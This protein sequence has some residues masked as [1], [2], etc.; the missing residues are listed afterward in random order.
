MLEAAL[1]CAVRGWPAFPCVPGKKTPLTEHGF[2]DA[3]T[4]PEV[5]RDWWRKWPDA[6]I[7]IATGVLSGLAVLDFDV[8]HAQPGATTYNELQAEHGK[9]K[10]R[11][12]GTPS[13]GRHLLYEYPGEFVKSCT[14]LKPGLDIRGDGGYIISPPSV[15]P[16]GKYE[17]LNDEPVAE[18]PDG[19][20]KLLTQ[21]K[22]SPA[23]DDVVTE[24]PLDGVA[25]GQRDE[26]AYDYVRDLHAAGVGRREAEVLVL[27]AAG[28]CDPPFNEAAA[29]DKVA[30]RYDDD[31]RV[32]PTLVPLD[33]P[34]LPQI[35]LANLPGWAGNFA[36]GLSVATES[37][38]EL[39]AAMVL[40]TCATAAARRLRVM[41]KPGYFEPCNLWLAVALPP[42]CRKSAIQGEAAAPLLAWEQDQAAA[43][44]PEIRRLTCEHAVLS[45][46][47]KAKTDKAAKAK[48]DIAAK[49]LAQEAADLEGELPTIPIPPQLWTSDCTPERMGSLLGD[50]GERLA[51][52]SSEGGLFDL[53]QGRYSSGVL[54]L[55]LTLKCHSGD[56][57]RVDRGSRP[58][59]FLRHPL[60]TVGM[61][62]QP[63][64]LRGLTG[65]PGFRGRGLLARFLYLLPASPLGNRT[66]DAPAIPDGVRTAYSAGIRAML[67]WSPASGEHGTDQPNLLKL[68]PAAHAVYLDFARHVESMMRPGGDFET[69]T[70]WAGK[71]PGAAARL[72]G[73][74]HGIK[75]AHGQPWG[76]EITVETMREALD[77]MAV[78]AR[79]SLAAFDLMGADDSIA[80]A[81]RVWRWIRH[82]GKTGLTVRDIFNALQSSFPHVH[83]IKDALAVLQE[84]GYV[85]VVQVKREGR[86]RKPSPVVHVR[87]EL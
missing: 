76:T 57:E 1:A 4:D 51:W 23:T 69:V 8:K 56:A 2:L 53:L 9:V 84:R 79:H 42:G 40:A 72:A 80:A 19:L 44:E 61:S 5:I 55:D 35:D 59:V 77:L 60:L 25:K 70:D 78:I 32:W 36:H 12:V 37:P 14:G 68:A 38:P 45:A 34:N 31:A 66:L 43:L 82:N 74:L 54:N 46:R 65:K 10:T 30:R 29:L 87:P 62:P 81:R 86:G 33:Q 6:N 85:D 58:P 16:E 47:V 22:A 7:G 18:L 27:H 52:L 15:T 75:H 73:V 39:A 11:M 3:T 83:E 48:T 71:C 20:R 67:D 21:G 49:V 24:S 17:W 28:N 41:V 50:N 13:G 64:V 63:E 26:M